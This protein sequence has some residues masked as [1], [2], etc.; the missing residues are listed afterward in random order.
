[1]YRLRIP[2]EIRDE[3]LGCVAQLPPVE[4]GAWLRAVFT[5]T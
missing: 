3:V 2:S 4:R 1:M 5:G